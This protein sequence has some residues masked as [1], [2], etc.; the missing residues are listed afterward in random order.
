[1][2]RLLPLMVLF[3]MSTE[4]TAATLTVGTGLGFDFSTL[5]SALNFSQSGDRILIQNGVYDVTRGELF[6][7]RIRS[8]VTL[9]PLTPG[10]RPIIRGDRSSATLLGEN[11]SDITLEGLEVRGGKGVRGGGLSLTNGSGEIRNCL[12]A[13]NEAAAG[14][15]V[16]SFGGRL[17]IE[18]CTFEYNQTTGRSFQEGGGGGMEAVGFD[19]TFRRCLFRKNRT[20][21]GESSG[22]GLSMFS[23]GSI[24][25]CTFI[26][27]GPTAFGGG[28]FLSGAIQVDHCQFIG[29]VAEFW[30][31]GAYI[32]YS[33]VTVSDSL[34]AA[35]R[36]LDIAD[37]GGGLVCDGTGDQAVLRCR[38]I[39]NWALRAGAVI[40][41]RET[42]AVFTNCLMAGNVGN[43]AGLSGVSN[44]QP[45]ASFCT[46]FKNFPRCVR[47]IETSS[48]NLSS[49][50][51]S[52]NELHDLTEVGGGAD[53]SAE[54]CYFNNESD[55]ILSDS[56][57]V[58]YR[59][60]EELEQA[61]EGFSDNLEGGRAFVGSSTGAWTEDGVFDEEAFQTV[62]VNNQAGWRPGEFEGLLTMV[63][64]ASDTQPLF[65]K[66]VTNTETTLTVWGDAAQLA[67]TGREYEIESLRTASGA[68]FTDRGSPT[69]P[70]VDLFGNPRPIDLLNLGRNQSGDEYDIGAIE[71]PLPRSFWRF[72]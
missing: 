14:G 23:D 56:S 8:G 64:P 38:F 49:C 16:S 54:Y 22:G 20:I 28:V 60:V 44:S 15:G 1:M 6:P 52:Q 27:N 35:N 10:T 66:I 72:F 7:I 68:P 24:S 53:I 2:S 37:G 3:L 9:T 58:T 69:G 46:F 11:V 21:T 19:H 42:E 32:F 31:G 17:L 4:V 55:G 39:G 48:I 29:N 61:V 45:T 12:F 43:G 63:N 25:D 59:T 26:D 71:I 47:A 65:F 36:A 70:D 34:F 30:G 67:K 13:D 18:D 5:S 50:L 57:G 33:S 62:L 41:F 51:F 40:C